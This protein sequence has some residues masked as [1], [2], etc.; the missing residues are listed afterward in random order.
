[1]PSGGDPADVA[2]ARESIRLAFVAALQHLPPRQRAVLILRDVLAWRAN[3]VAGLLELSVP[4]VNSA[5]N[6][7][8]TR[9]ST[10]SSTIAPT[11]RPPS[12][13]P[14]RL[15][16]LLE[17]YVRAWESAD[18]AGLVALLREDAVVSMPP[19]ILVLGRRAIGA[20][21]A[22]S[23]FGAGIRIRLVPVGANRTPAFA[24]YSGG[25][26]DDVVR[27]YA[28]LL[29]GILDER[30][31]RIDVFADP[32]LAATFGLADELPA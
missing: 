25:P 26:T 1:V 9:M 4:A 13:E 32:R 10:Q 2:V 7:A 17:R 12:T 14:N 18:V 28:L 27:M 3:E 29:V 30:I 31:A 6:R 23:V 5:L 19:G 11:Q 21:V 20:F 24:V 22:D 8:R 16:T 15:R